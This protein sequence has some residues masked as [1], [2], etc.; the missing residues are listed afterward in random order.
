M[1]QF[2]M[3]TFAARM[4]ECMELCETNGYEFI[5]QGVV[6][7]GH[8]LYTALTNLDDRL[9]LE[10]PVSEDLQTGFALGVAIAGGSVVS[11][12]PRFDFLL[13]GFNQLINHV[14][15]YPVMARFKPRINIIY[16]VG[17]GSTSPLDAGPQHTNNYSKQ[18]S[19]MCKTI[20]VVDF[21]GPCDPLPYYEEAV[22]KGGVWVMVEH[23]GEAGNDIEL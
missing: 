22:K 12:Y 6:A 8:S 13:V 3:K 10:F 19:E 18:L 14:D 1:G 17:V 9:K 11:I 5:G 21:H 2:L 23:H 4:V 20:A 15:K 16:R 7:G